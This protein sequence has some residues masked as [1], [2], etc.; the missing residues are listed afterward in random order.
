MISREIFLKA[1]ADL[2]PVLTG[3]GYYMNDCVELERVDGH[4]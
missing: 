3:Y 4:D 1:L 2:E